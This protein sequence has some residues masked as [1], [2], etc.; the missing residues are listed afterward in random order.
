L[1]TAME[2]VIKSWGVYLG[3]SRDAVVIRQRGGGERRVPIYQVDRIW[4]LTGG[5]AISSKLLR[6]CARR[7]IDVVIFD[8][9]GMPLARVFPPEANGT[10]SH[11]RAQYEA[12]FNGR[13]FEL[14]KLVVY[15]KV[16]NQSRASRRL[17]YNRRELYERLVDA[18]GKV[19]ELGPRLLAC[20][21]AQCVLAYEGQAAQVY[22]GAVSELGFPSRDPEGGDP[23][24]LALN[25]GYGLLRYAVWRQVV[26]HG[27]DPYAG[28]LHVDKSGRPSLVLDLMEEF[29]P[30]V[31]LMVIKLRPS[32]EW[33]EGGLLKREKRAALVEAWLSLGLEPAVA[34]QVGAA[35]AH[36]EGRAAYAPHVL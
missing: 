26:V 7:F 3:F 13:G 11:R 10:V 29:R 8:G 30:H 21:D 15:G 17:A 22:W 20:G 23:F 36:L 6:E 18:A 33:V 16:V 12:Y 34:R 19:A 28:F 5:V 27:L 1:P 2:L 14:A 24:N 35:V 31:D 32:A 9:R 4:I 25:Y